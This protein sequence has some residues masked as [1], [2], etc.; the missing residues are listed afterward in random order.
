MTGRDFAVTADLV[1]EDIS[2]G[3]MAGALKHPDKPALLFEDRC[4][5][6]AQLAERIQRV[7]ALA[8]DELGLGPGDCAACAAETVRTRQKTASRQ[9]LSDR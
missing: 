5:S 2:S 7:A 9:P 1:G 6:F 4:L 8:R 3:V